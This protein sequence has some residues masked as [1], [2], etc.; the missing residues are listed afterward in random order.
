MKSYGQAAKRRQIKNAVRDEMSRYAEH[1][2]LCMLTTVRRKFRCGKKG[3]REFYEEFSKTY[4]DFKRRYYDKD[5]EKIFGE[6]GD[7]YEMRE[8]LLNIGYDYDAEVKRLSE[9]KEAEQCQE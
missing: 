6:R 5:D 1:F 2:D 8:A 4:D 9:Q 3:L 7:T